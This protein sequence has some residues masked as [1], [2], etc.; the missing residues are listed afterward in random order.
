MALSSDKSRL[1]SPGPACAY[2]RDSA[3]APSPRLDLEASCFPYSWALHGVHL[4]AP[5]LGV[6]PSDLPID[7]IAPR[8]ACPGSPWEATWIEAA[9]GAAI[10]MRAE[11]GRA[12]VWIWSPR[13][14]P[15]KQQ[16]A[17][18]VGSAALSGVSACRLGVEVPAETLRTLSAADQESLTAL[19]TAGLQAAVRIVPRWGGQTRRTSR[20]PTAAD[21]GGLTVPS[22]GIAALTAHANSLRMIVIAAGVL[23]R[24]AALEL[25]SAGVTAV[26]GPVV[27]APMGVEQMRRFLG[28]CEQW[29]EKMRADSL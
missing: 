10:S 19:H 7:H 4:G 29:L 14:I 22:G 2:G 6:V 13:G 26:H 5:P 24:A 18:L 23:D 1:Q 27:S 21:R 28:P 17:L 3:G 11:L 25:G 15:G 20:A 12:R 16:L 9:L 8:P